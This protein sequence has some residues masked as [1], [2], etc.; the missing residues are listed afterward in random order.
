MKL[1]LSL[2]ITFV[3]LGLA[4]SASLFD[5]SSP[6]QAAAILWSETVIDS[7][8]GDF[9]PGTGLGDLA[10]STNGTLVEAANFGTLSNYTVNS[11]LFGGVDFDMSNPTNLTIAYDSADNFDDG[12]V[13]GTSTGGT[14]DNLTTS[15][16]RDAGVGMHSATLTGLTI[17]Q[18]YEVQFV[19]SFAGLG[20]STTFDDGSGRT[21]AQSTN[22]PHAFATGLFT[23]DATTQTIEMTASA[24]SQFVSAYQLRAVNNAPLFPP[25][26][27]INRD[28]GSM[29]LSTEVNTNFIGYSITSELAALDQSGWTPVT[30]NYDISSGPGDGSV[31][32]DDPWTVVS[33]PSSSSDLSEVQLGGPGPGDGGLISTSSPIVLSAAGGWRQFY[34]EDVEMSILRPDGTTEEL[35]VE[36]VGNGGAPF[37]QGD[38]DFDGD[39][40]ADDHALFAAGMHTD[41]L[42]LPLIDAYTMG[43]LNQDRLNNVQ[44]FLLFQTIYDDVNG[45]GAFAALQSAV[46]PEPSAILLLLTGMLLMTGREMKH[47]RYSMSFPRN[48]K[49]CLPLFVGLLTL[50][51]LAVGGTARAADIAWTEVV[52]DTTDG[53]SDPGTGLGDLA[54]STAGT[55]VEAANFGILDDFV[56]NG[57]PFNGVDFDSSMPTNLNIAYDSA[58]NIPSFGN[59]GTSTGGTIDDITAS[60]SRDNL[61]SVQNATLTGLTIGTNY[62]VQFVASFANLNRTTTFDDGNGNNI[63]QST[64]NPHSFS[65]GVFTADATTQAIDMTISSGSQFLSAYQLRELDNNP[66]FLDLLYDPTNGLMEINNQTGDA[67]D[68][69][70]YEI[71]STTGSLDPAGWNSLDDQNIG[72]G[73][74]AGESWTEAG[75]SDSEIL[76]EFFTLGSTSIADGGELSLGSAF[77]VGSPQTLEFNYLVAG[78]PIL[79]TGTVTVG[80]IA[81]APGDADGDGDVDGADFLLLQ[82]TNPAQIPTWQAN[83]GNGV[84]LSAATAVPEPS[85]LALLLLVG[86]AI[87]LVRSRE[88]AAVASLVYARSRSLGAVQTVGLMRQLLSLTLVML[89]ASPA[90]A[91]VTNDREYWFGEDSLEGASQG[92]IIGGSNTSPLPSGNSADSKGP[93]GAFLDLTRGGNPTY[94]DVDATGGLN[95]PGASNGDY[96][97]R[98]D[99]VGDVLNAFPL[100][101]PDALDDVVGGGYPLNYDGIKGRGLQL[102]VYPDASAL[103]SEGNPTS[104]QSIVADTNRGGGPAINELGQWTQISGNRIDGNN[105]AAAVP[106]SVDVPAGDT[107]YHVMHQ[108]YPISGDSFLS[109]LYVDGTAVSANN[110]TIRTTPDAGYVPKLTVGAA[111]IPNDGVFASYDL[112][113]TGVVDDLEMYVFGD[114]SSQ[115]GQNYGTFDLF[116]DNEWIANE[117]ANTVPGGILQPGDVNKDGSVNGDGSGPVGSDDVSAFIAGWLSE[118]TLP[119]VN[120]TLAAGDWNTWDNGDMNHDGVTDLGDAFILHEALKGAGLAGL[121][122][123]LLAATVPEPSSALLVSLST[124]FVLGS[125]RGRRQS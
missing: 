96:G 49:A 57:V 41:M 74:A 10:V 30:D 1:S 47:R 54:V 65:T 113:F 106:A 56:V 79:T 125:R 21:I 58:F 86:A 61:V 27:N 109:V 53:D 60:F 11:V 118:N 112:F 97:A 19:A 94:Q 48:A 119:A 67:I 114:N 34:E 29:T 89:T 31:D 52:I 9:S 16:A 108:N 78:S 87:L 5:A 93:S 22:N 101:R 110:A 81:A 115:G 76:S 99:G 36:F 4:I 104:F 83:Y 23:A 42:S 75:G 40:D 69:N 62:E 44:D 71:T 7:T 59:G 120:G 20:R 6:V 24:G 13:T 121:D 82:R 111:E 46:V 100:N 12:G 66:L 63:V 15:F 50:A 28:T 95:R 124:I 98:F 55:L 64:N 103:G 38:F 33:S 70:Y 35:F 26:L 117:I 51:G 18:N 107:W 14:I 39:I 92:A 8:D 91:A 68:L 17:G 123:S 85:S 105:G 84:P 37:D 72:F 43:D 73:P 122:F 90:L 77:N 3:A 2:P 88:Q 102:W 80:T 116:A 45:P 25:K 32:A